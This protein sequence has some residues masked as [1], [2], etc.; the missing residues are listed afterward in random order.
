MSE[1]PPENVVPE[2]TRQEMMFPAI[3][4]VTSSPG[5]ALATPALRLAAALVPW[6]T[7]SFGVPV[8]QVQHIEV[9]D[10]PDADAEMQRLLAWFDS[11]GVELAACRLDHSRLLESA[12]LER[13]GFRFIE[14]VYG[15]EI[16]PQRLQPE[17][18]PPLEVQWRRACEAD[19]AE[20]QQ[21]AGDAF[22]TGRWN[23]DWSVGQALGGRRYA[24]WVVRSLVDAKHEVLCSVVDGQTTGLF[25][26][27]PAGD[28]SVYW[29]LTAVAPKWQGKGIGKAMWGSM[30][31]RHAQDG[32]TTVHTTISARNLPVV[33]L[34]SRLGW[35][36]VNCQMSYHWAAAQWLARES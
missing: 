19:L 29:H 25:I 22:A 12:A 8:A 9:H 31:H 20:L 24:D 34:Y 16:N 11:Q 27:E 32:A 1:L 35:R 28:G 26:V 7:A 10:R 18:D 13:I 2:V 21:L 36:F 6:D 3:A 5:L 4:K 15:M 14:M 30:L 17:A 23:M 33:N